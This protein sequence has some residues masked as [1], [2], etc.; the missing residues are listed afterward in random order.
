VRT[1]L[2]VALLSLSAC[3]I[4]AQFG[5]APRIDRMS[6]LKRG[7]STEADVLL[8]LGEPR[9]RGMARLSPTAAPRKVWLYELR[10]VQ[11]TIGR[12]NVLLVFLD[13][14]RFDGYLWYSSNELQG[15]Q[16]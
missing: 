1:G 13:G 3:A 15:V 14:E 6:T 4:N 8:A 16:K 12:Q 5:A 9:G 10:R 2:V 11:G 7:E